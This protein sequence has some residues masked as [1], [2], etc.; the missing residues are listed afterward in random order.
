MWTV[1]TV[2][3]KIQQLVGE[4]EGAFYNISSRMHDISRAQ[5]EMVRE[6]GAL[7]KNVLLSADSGFGS[8]SEAFDSAFESGG[9]GDAANLRLPSDFVKLGGRQ[10]VVLVGTSH[11]PVEIVP[12]RVLD[13]LYPAWRVSSSLGNTPQYAMIENNFLAPIPVPSEA[14]EID[15]QY[16]YSP[17]LTE[18]TQVPFDSRPDLNEFAQALA[19]RVASD[20]LMIGAPE[21]SAML[22]QAYVGEINRM[23]HFTRTSPPKDYHIYPALGSY[24]AARY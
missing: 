20:I 16:V 12:S 8:F 24:Y 14:F 10:P 6:S 19:Y 23:R 9:T 3:N 13:T 1:E 17:A 4:P 21:T 5:S 22:R 15:V 18:F 11:Y 7:I 2:L